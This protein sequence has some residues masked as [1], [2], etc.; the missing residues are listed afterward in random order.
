[1][2]LNK[3]TV[4]LAAAGLVSLGQNAQAEEAGN[5]VMTAFSKTTLSGFVD[6]S[7]SISEKGANQALHGRVPYQS[8][9][10][11]NGIN[12]DVI[13]L[14]LASPLDESD[15]AA[16]YAVDLLF[17]PDASAY[18]VSGT[19]EA[20]DVAVRQAYVNTRVPVGNGL[21]LKMGVFDAI[22]G[23]EGFSNRDNPNYSRNM[24]YNLQPFNHTGLLGGYQI[25]DLVS[26]QFGVANTG[27]N[28]L[29]DRA[30][31]SSDISYMGS[32]A[33]E[34]PENFGALAGATVYVGYMEFG[35]GGDE[36]QNLYVG[37]TIPT[38][39][40]GLALGAA[41]DNVQNITGNGGDANILAGYISYQATDKM[42]V[43]G[44]IEYLDGDQ[45]V[46]FNA[47]KNGVAVDSEM[48]SLTGTVQY[49]LWDNVLTRAEVRWD[50]QED[51]DGLYGGDD[52]ILTF[53]LNAI[54]SF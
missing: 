43:N 36:Q 9:N 37:S 27:S 24:A 23:Y 39:I 17:G 8:G 42:A 6:T 13:Q 18:S 28:V 21:D 4:A 50:S 35:G 40:D 11:M 48:L 31:D 15:W 2:K 41:W 5:A 45:G 33:V 19:G 22:I 1:M 26:A 47:S 52:D 30:A 53:T 44:R 7:L 54:Y 29:T 46:L 3:W 16:G 34:A 12:L 14:S 25:N 10:K 20:D 49:D 38:P 51:G 32:V